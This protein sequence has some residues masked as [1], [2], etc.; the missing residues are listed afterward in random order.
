MVVQIPNRAGRNLAIAVS[1][2][3]FLTFST[4]ALLR[5]ATF[6]MTAFDAGI[7]DNVLW[8]VSNG[9]GDVT[10]L[11]GAHHFSDHLSL[12]ILLAIPIYATVPSLG[13]PA[14][15]IAQAASV[16]LVPY[17]T[18]LLAAHYGLSRDLRRALLIL[19]ALSAATWNAA[20]IDIHEVGLAVG[21]LAMTVALGLRGSSSRTYWIWPA[22]AAAARVDIAVAVLIIGVLLRS[23]QPE[24][25]RATMAV[26]GG[27]ATMMIA[28]LLL[29]PWEGT[30]FAF[31]FGH[32]G[33]A[34][35]TEL[36]LA[37]LR[38]PSGALGE[39]FDT[40]MLASVA[41][42]L[43]GFTLIAP[44]AAWRWLLPAAPT[45]IIP[46]F[47]SWPSADLS[48]VHYWHVLLPMLAVATVVG[49]ARSPQLHR[50]FFYLTVAAV[51]LTW[52]AMGI[53]K[54]AFSND[55]TDLRAVTAY[56]KDR[57]AASI[58][59]PAPLVAQLSARESIMQLP[60][61][62]S[63]PEPP[64]AF[65]AP[66]EKPPELVAVPSALMSQP[67]AGPAAAVERALRLDYALEAEFGTL[68]VWRL[69]GVPPRAAYD[70]RCTADNSS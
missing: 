35:A 65:F 20:V 63:C 32:L 27:M 44:L 54:P 47:G 57:P 15:I 5:L 61:P 69:S 2:A 58:A 34:S 38:D 64:L 67:Q 13:L 26:G 49:L 50:P 25:A 17:A 6:D 48:H 59:V 24:K 3:A 55:L 22:L 4:F 68:Q 40:T 30:S 11:T 1:S 14:L 33:V 18:Y 23:R 36:P 28:W 70:A 41:V 39:L 21:P 7:F 12:L 52:V 46:V 42:W 43:A 19:T 37:A 29:N 62:F 16:A 60:T 10:D 53:F 45:V 66:P 51:A 56:L 31:H 8:R 9:Y